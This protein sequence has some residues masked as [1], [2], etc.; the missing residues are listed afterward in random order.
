MKPR[1]IWRI[2][3]EQLCVTFGQAHVHKHGKHTLD[4][5]CVA[6]INATT[7]EEANKLAFGWWDG[8]FHQHVDRKK[9]NDD[10]MKYFPRGY[11]EI[12]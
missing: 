8:V 7:I 3:M 1:L 11:I 12:N 4:K 5:D 9:W 6:V 10:D 2:M